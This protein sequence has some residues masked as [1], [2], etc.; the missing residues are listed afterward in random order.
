LCV[1][2]LAHSST[3]YPFYACSTLPSFTSLHP[4]LFSFQLYADFTP[5]TAENFRCLCTG[6]RGVSAR[7]GLPLS[8]KGSSFHRIIPGF[9]AQGGDFTRGDGTGGESIYGDKF[10]DENFILT[11][12]GGGLLSMAN[13]G[14]NTN[15]SQFFV[16]F[17]KAPHLNGRHTV[18]GRVSEGMASVVGLLQKTATDGGDRPRFDVA[19]TDCGQLGVSVLEKGIA[20]GQPSGTSARSA[21]DD[22][23][24]HLLED[25]DAG[26]GEAGGG[27]AGGDG[28]PEAEEE[29]DEEEPEEEEPDEEALG[30]MNEKQKRLFKLRMMINKGRKA[31]RSAA[32]EEKKRLDDP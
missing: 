8:F 11:H 24:D 3:T 23:L 14:P 18:F 21:A 28:E 17:G 1:F 27:T 32:A 7:S 29:E 12:D 5:R 10:P 9:M 26:D 13:A 31:N 16:T 20:V 22:D 30:K 15:G 25:G 19:V 2:L 6:E 4:L